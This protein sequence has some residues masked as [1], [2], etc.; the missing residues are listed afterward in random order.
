M[1]FRT[2]FTA[3]AF[4]DGVGWAVKAASLTFNAS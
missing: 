3:S 4:L 1:V 2:T